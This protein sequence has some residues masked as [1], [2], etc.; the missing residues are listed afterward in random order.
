MELS[1]V[2]KMEIT[3]LIKNDLFKKI[4]ETFLF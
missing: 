3:K 4:L 1:P 2:F